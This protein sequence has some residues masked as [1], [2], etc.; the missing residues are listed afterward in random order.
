MTRERL[1]VHNKITSNGQS[2]SPKP[3]QVSRKMYHTPKT[4]GFAS[5]PPRPQRIPLHHQ[6]L[7]QNKRTDVFTVSWPP[8][9]PPKGVPG[10]PPPRSY[11]HD[12]DVSVGHEFEGVTLSP[13]CSYVDFFDTYWRKQGCLPNE[14]A[15]EAWRRGVGKEGIVKQ[16]QRYEDQRALEQEVKKRHVSESGQKEWSSN[17]GEGPSGPTNHEYLSSSDA[18]RK[19]ETS[20]ESVA[21]DEGCMVINDAGS[22]KR[23][24]IKVPR[25]GKWW[26]D[27]DDMTWAFG[28]QVPDEV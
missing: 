21:G 10:N 5:L 16:K 2:V 25:A 18:S 4:P 12:D 22:D 23:G 15:R 14:A 9:L 3:Y 28:N 19:G 11:P 1:E 13:N 24:G 20:R 6:S 26:K 8:E 7:V 17:L 27:I